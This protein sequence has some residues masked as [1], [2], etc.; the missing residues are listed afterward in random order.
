MA[1]HFEPPYYSVSLYSLAII[2]EVLVCLQH[3]EV[4]TGSLGLTPF[5]L[6]NQYEFVRSTVSN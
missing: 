2:D 1:N 5:L 3:I 4:E 6:M